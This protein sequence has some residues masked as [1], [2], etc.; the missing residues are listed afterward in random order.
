LAERYRVYQEELGLSEEDADILSG[1]PALADL[2]DAARA[3]RDD[4]GPVANWMIHELRGLIGGRAIGDLPFDGA[5][6]GELVVLVES[7][8][9][10]RTVGRSVLERLIEDGG[11]PGR[12]VEERGLERIADPDALSPIVER[13]VAGHPDEVERYRSGQEGLIGF[14]VGRVMDATDGKAD[15]GRARELLRE[16]LAD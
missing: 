8:T 2:F 15:P 13:V 11:D 4:A 10:T 1:D 12:I 6:F 9:I 5:A 7:G 14:F 3:G 16:A